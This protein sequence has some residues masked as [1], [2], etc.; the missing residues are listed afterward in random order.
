MLKLNLSSATIKRFAFI[1]LILWLCSVTAPYSIYAQVAEAE[2]VDEFGK[3]SDEE[4][5]AR[6][7]NILIRLNNEP[8]VSAQFLLSRGENQTPGAARRLFGIMRGYLIYHKIDRSRLLA[9]FCKPQP[10]E[11]TQIWMIPPSVG[12]KTCEPDIIV[13][14]KTVLYDSVFHANNYFGATTR[15]EEIAHS[16]TVPTLE[17]FAELLRLLPDAKGYVFIYGGTNVYWTRDSRDRTKTVRNKDSPTE[18]RKMTVMASEVFRDRGLR[19]RVVVH[20]AGYRDSYAEIEM[21]IVPNGG[22]KPVPSRTYPKVKAT[23]D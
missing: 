19:S 16:W 11:N 5:Q 6:L 21:W 20:E 2:Q 14:D 10:E 7:D 9:T 3:W 8:T 12:K 18:I 1:V 17:E 13:F 22:R 4:L 23:V 15:I